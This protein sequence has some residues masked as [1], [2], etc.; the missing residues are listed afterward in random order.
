MAETT[1]T[2]NHYPDV[3]WAHTQT[4]TNQN[5]FADTG[6]VAIRI[7]NETLTLGRDGMIHPNTID[8]SSIYPL[9]GEPYPGSTISLGTPGSRTLIIY[10]DPNRLFDLNDTER[11]NLAAKASQELVIAFHQQ[12]TTRRVAD[13]GEQL[14]M[15]LQGLQILVE[16]T[17]AKADAGIVEKLVQTLRDS[18][19][20]ERILQICNR[21][22][23]LG[24]EDICEALGKQHSYHPKWL[25]DFYTKGQMVS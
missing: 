2:I 7:G 11:I 14:A 8:T 22:V 5:E 13:E 21:L 23:E 15:Q 3:S 25:I 19:N 17:Q 1:L 20:P 9:R 12:Q 6:I 24:V 16:T 4:D 10:S 18:V